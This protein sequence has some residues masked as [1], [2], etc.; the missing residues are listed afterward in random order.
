MTSFQSYYIF[1]TQK[2][3]SPNDCR[4]NLVRYSNEIVKYE[5][6]QTFKRSTEIQTEMEIN[7]LLYLIVRIGKLFIKQILSVDDAIEKAL[8]LLRLNLFYNSSKKR[9][10]VQK[11]T[12]SVYEYQYTTMQRS[13]MKNKKIY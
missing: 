7:K 1:T 6:E 13:R 12:N 11:Y 5:V 3:C 9:H 4:V 10:T 8:T 2:L